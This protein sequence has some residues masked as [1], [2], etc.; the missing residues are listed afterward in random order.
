MSSERDGRG[1]EEGPDEQGQAWRPTP[2]MKV[3]PPRRAGPG[4][5]KR[6]ASS[7]TSAASASRRGRVVAAVD[8]L[9]DEPGDRPHLVR[10][11]AAGR[12]R[13]AS[14]SGSPTTVLGGSGSNGIAFLLTVIPTS[15]RS[16]LGL[17]A[18][19]AEGRD[20]D[21]HQVVVRAARDDLRAAR[22]R[23][24]PARTRGVLD[25]SHLVAPEVLARGEPEADGLAGDDVHERPAL[26]AREDRLVD[27]RRRG[28]S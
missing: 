3:T 15:S 1:G 7:A 4:T 12:R 2:S 20:V 6:A 18:G 23:G 17:L 13:P 27:L 14:R 22:R 9:G 11:E 19:H 10:P 24:S 5:G 16:V 21:E 28:S 25:R 26:D 8:R